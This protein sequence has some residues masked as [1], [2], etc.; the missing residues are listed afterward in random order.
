VA[1]DVVNPDIDTDDDI[2]RIAAL[3]PISRDILQFTTQWGNVQPETITIQPTGAGVAT[4]LAAR[5]ARLSEVADETGTDQARINLAATR[6]NSNG[7]AMTLPRTLAPTAEPDTLPLGLFVQGAPGGTVMTPVASG[8]FRGLRLVGTAITLTLTDDALE[9]D[10]YI[11]VSSVA[12]RSVGEYLYIG[13]TIDS[14]NARS[15]TSRIRWVDTD[16]SRLYYEDRLTFD[17]AVADTETIEVWTG[18]YDGGGVKD[19]AVNG[20]GADGTTAIGVLVER[21]ANVRVENLRGL[22]L[23][24][25]DPYQSGG[26][27]GSA[28]YVNRAYGVRLQ[29]KSRNCGSNNLAGGNIRYAT[30]CEID[31]EADEG[32]LGCNVQFG[33]YNHIKR[34]RVNGTQNRGF[35][36]EG[37]RELEFDS[38]I[39]H[40]ARY[41]GAA[42]RKGTTAVGKYLEVGRHRAPPEIVSIVVASNVATVVTRRPYMSEVGRAFTI[43]G[44]TETPLNDDHTVLA[45]LSSTSFTFAVTSINENPAAGSPVFTSPDSASVWLDGGNVVHVEKVKI[46]DA[47]DPFG[48]FK[49]TSTD[50]LVIGD[51]ITDAVPTFT[52]TAVLGVNIIVD[53]INGVPQADY[54]GWKQIT[55]VTFGSGSGDVNMTL[56]GGTGAGIGPALKLQRNSVEI[57]SLGPFSAVV[58]TGSNSSELVLRA[59][60]GHALVNGSDAYMLRW[61]TSAQQTM[62]GNL[63]WNSD[64]LGSIGFSGSFRPSNIF[65]TGII[66]GNTVQIVDGVTAPSATSGLMKMFVNSSGNDFEV[67]FGDGVTKTVALDT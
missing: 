62:F 53:K 59:T 58:G 32:P 12:G 43:D 23:T 35:K 14:E 15:L 24:T 64:G 1:I 56:N 26:V 55:S 40:N 54:A 60:S 66:G 44:C 51:L 5:F 41:T 8:A 46:I 57:G 31:V 27:N 61:N 10:D 30:K 17:V 48:D 20:A 63:I 7:V 22:D 18:V 47:G 9:G 33:S 34:V 49:V 4:T 13:K 42:F 2:A 50:R 39:V 29:V 67:I 65:G 21:A 38:I 45:V 37:E 25:P 11:E 52:D 36:A 6:A 16:R 19:F 28:L 3:E